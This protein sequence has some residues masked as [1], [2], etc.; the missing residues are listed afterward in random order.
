MNKPL[1]TVPVPMRPDR[2]EVINLVGSGQYFELANG[3]QY[4]GLVGESCGARNLASGIVTF[5]PNT[6]LPYHTHPQSESITLLEGKAAVEVE[7]RHY[8]LGVLDNLVLPRGL[9]HQ[10]SNIST[11][12][13]AVFH[14][15]FAT[16]TPT[17]TLV[18]TRFSRQDMPGLSPGKAGAERLNW[19]QSA[20]WYEGGD[21]ANFMDYFNSRLMPGIEMSGGYALFEPGG[22]LPCHIHDFDESICIIQGTAT[23]VVDGRQ[24]TMSNNA[25]AFQPRGKCHYFINN[26]NEPMAMIWVYAGSLPERIEMS[27]AACTTIRKHGKS[28]SDR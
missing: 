12:E 4:D 6:Y 5:A 21:R 26:S 18:E 28:E 16:E 7:G 25:T 13:R 27:E 9:A 24:Y 17:R 11:S 15:A 3:I 19:H 14:V 22:R 2:P 10:V 1:D 23:C 20:Q 8:T